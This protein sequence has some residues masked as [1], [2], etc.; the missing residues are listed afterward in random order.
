M[1]TLDSMVEETIGTL[2]AFST[3]QD[4][5]TSLTGSMTSN[6]LTF[7]VTDTDRLSGGLVE[8]DEELI[9]VSEVDT[10]GG[11]V[12]IYPWGR[13]QQGS[14]AATHAVGA[15][16]TVTPRWPRARIKRVINE[17]IN[18]LWPDL[19]AVFLDESN[20][21]SA[22]TIAYPLPAT[23]RRILDIRWDSPGTP[24]YWVGVRAWRLDLAADPTAFPTGVAVDVPEAMWPGRTLK[25]VYAAEPT[26]LVGG[27][28]DFATITG[29][30]ATVADLVCIGA[31]A[32]LVVTSDL[33]RTQ[34]FTLEHAARLES[35]TAG[36][37]T[38]VSR[39]LQQLYQVRLAAE[40]DRLF[41]R[42]PIKVQ[43][44]WL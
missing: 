15:R 23:C 17:T 38:A 22:T 10:L 34:S 33:A 25:V 40:R 19:F 5:K 12:N 39:Y 37:A 35:Q 7:T 31:A 20:T 44:T 11:S 4:Q 13:G 28:D 9:E 41:G 2:R 26:E 18:S 24:V 14:T 21:T 27:S 29:L 42:Y 8:I 16:V 3:D 43:R 1:P 6:V 36:S 32:R 30:P